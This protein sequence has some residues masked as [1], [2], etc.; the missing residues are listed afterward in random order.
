MKK[1]LLDT[2]AWFRIANNEAAFSKK[3]IEQINLSAENEQLFIASITLWEIA[4]LEAKN[5]IKLT[6]HCLH[7]IQEAIHLTAVQILDLNSTISV[8]SCNLPENFHQDPADRIIV[9]TARVH[10][11]C[12]VTA[13][14]AIL[15][16]AK[17]HQYIKTLAIHTQ[18]T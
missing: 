12:L 4:M 14:K 15:Q 5:R 10:D 13:D 3:I 8:E 11:L 18:K 17:Q 1:F 16:Y 7:W 6:P 9:A 2:H